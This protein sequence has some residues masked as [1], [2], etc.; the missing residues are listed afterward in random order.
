MAENNLT[1][2]NKV[3]IFIS[4]SALIIGLLF[5]LGYV[6][7]ILLL[8]FAGILLAVL[9]RA[10]SRIL[11]KFLPLSES[12]ALLVV[13]VLLLF[14]ITGFGMIIGP[15]LMEGLG[16]LA[17]KIPSSIEKLKETI[18]QYSWGGFFIKNLEKLLM[19]I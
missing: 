5:F 13:I 17:D 19:I 11:Q 3:L 6:V 12:I 14:I 9:L 1:F 18:K 7:N 2:S 15:N 10:L 4:I 8:V 16:N